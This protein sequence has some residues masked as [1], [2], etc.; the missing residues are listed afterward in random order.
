MIVAARYISGPLSGTAQ[1]SAK[2]TAPAGGGVVL[3]V[4]TAANLPANVTTD[5]TGQNAGTVNYMQL[6]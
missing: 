1:I 2:A 3:I 5:V 6:V 4:S